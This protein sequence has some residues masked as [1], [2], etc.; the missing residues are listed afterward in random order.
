[1]KKSPSA[2]KKHVLNFRLDDKELEFVLAN[3]L[4]AQLSLSEYIRRMVLGSRIETQE[5]ILISEEIRKMVADLG[6]LGGLLKLAISEDKAEK[7]RVYPILRDLKVITQHLRN[8]I[9]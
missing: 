5:E 8:K 2:L 9:V 6:R 7:L 1:M 4:K 3:Q